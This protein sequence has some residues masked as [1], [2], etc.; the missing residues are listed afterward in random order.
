M[1]NKALVF[2]APHEA[3]ILPAED[4]A[5]REGEARMRL[6]YSAI[7][8][9]TERLVFEGGVPTSEY[10]R[11]RA[12]FQV[13]DFPFPVRY[14]YAAVGE[15]VAGPAD[16]IGRQAFA[17]APHQLF[18]T[19]PCSA[20]TLLP[21]ATPP[22]RAP[23][24]ANLETA[25]N[26]LWDGGF[27]PGDRI[28]IVGAGVLGG[29]VAA[30]ASA[31][32]GA[33]VWMIDM[34]PE[35]A[36]LAAELGAQFLSAEAAKDRVL[37]ADLVIHTSASAAGL[38]LALR[39]AGAEATVVEA[40]WYGAQRPALPLGEA[41]HSRR[42]RLISSQVGLTPLERRPRWPNARRLTKAVEMLADPRYEALISR[43]VA[44]ADLPAALAEI[45]GP[46]AP[47]LATI[48]RYPDEA[49]I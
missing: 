14:G 23:L 3:A 47:G 17:L 42:L 45:L 29:L 10:Q 48:V 36:A 5:P 41:F 24:A 6:L 13:G 18:F 4:P 40:S 26:A 31:T 33:E 37:E 39:L 43:D 1:T 21:E 34:E 19:G 2:Q 15:I 25:L 38:E 11:M 28:A 46:S 44:F 35:R 32:P 7:S 8:R 27:A 20:F 30:I 9:G 12:P 22:R 49:A 16:W